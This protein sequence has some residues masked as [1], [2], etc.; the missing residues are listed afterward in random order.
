L[1]SIYSAKLN[2]VTFRISQANTIAARKIQD[3]NETALDDSSTTVPLTRPMSVL[4]SFMLWA[5]F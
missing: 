5:Q 1:Q 3:C 4:I 2:R